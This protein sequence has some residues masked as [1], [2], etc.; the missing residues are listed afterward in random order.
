KCRLRAVEPG[1]YGVPLTAEQAGRLRTIFPGG[2]CD[3]SA[4]GIG[5]QGLAGTWQSCGR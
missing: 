3:W 5:Q 4:P 2:V 1:A